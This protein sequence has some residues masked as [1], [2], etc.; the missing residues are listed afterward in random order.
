MWCCKIFGHT[1]AECPKNLDLGAGA[2]EKKKKKPSQAPKGIPVSP[3]MAF[4]TNQEYRPVPKKNT[5]NSSGNK[6]KGV[7]STNKM[8]TYG[9][10]LP[11]WNIGIAIKLYEWAGNL[12]APELVLDHHLLERSEVNL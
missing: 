7:D 5:S 12:V 10:C 4:K 3:K 11:F 6:N 9:L 1:Q 2:S 8:C